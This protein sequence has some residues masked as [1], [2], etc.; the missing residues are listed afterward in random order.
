MYKEKIR[1]LAIRFSKLRSELEKK[2]R[3]SW[4]TF[5]AFGKFKFKPQKDFP[6]TSPN[7]N[8]ELV[9][10]YIE[11]LDNLIFTR[12]EKVREIAV[13]APFSGGKSSFLRTYMKQRPSLLIEIISLAAFKSEKKET[14]ERDSD[15]DQTWTSGN[16]ESDT[17]DVSKE[18]R[19]EKSILQQLLYRTS[20]NR[21]TYS[22][23]RRIFP[24][25]L[26]RITGLLMSLWLITTG[27]FYYSIFTNTINID[28][29]IQSLLEYDSL[30]WD[31]Y[32]SVEFLSIVFCT[33]LPVLLV[34]DSIQFFRSYSLTKLNPL[35]GEFAFSEKSNDSIFNKYLEEIIYYFAEQKTDIVIFEDL[36]RF[37]TLE[38]FV[39]LKELNKLVND[40]A[41]VKQPVRFIYALKDDVFKGKT[42]TKFFDSI[43]PIVPYTNTSNS[44]PELT[45]LIKKYLFDK[46]FGDE[47]LRDISVFLDDMRMIN[48]IVAEYAIYKDV[49]MESSANRDLKKL[50]AF[51][52]YKN[53]YSDDFALLNENSGK[54]A[55]CFNSIAKIRDTVRVSITSEIEDLEKR[56]TQIESEKLEDEEE[57]I[58]L[59]FRKIFIK[60]Y[61]KRHR[62]INT[63]L[64]IDITDLFEHAKF[65]EHYGSLSQHTFQSNDGHNRNQNMTFKTYVAKLFPT[66]DTRL[67]LLRDKTSNQKKNI[68]AQISE[69]RQKNSKISQES[70]AAICK[71]HGKDLIFE[72]FKS[73]NAKDA[74]KYDLL[75]HM[76]ERGYLDQHYHLYIY[77]HRDGV[78]N[79]E[80]LAYLRT[81]KRG[82]DVLADYLPTDIAEFIKYL[83]N[84]DYSRKSFFNIVIINKML[85]NALQENAVR[86]HFSSA[87][88]DELELL[89]L[90]L[91]HREEFLFP[92]RISWMIYE[93]QQ[94][95]LS[96]ITTSDASDSHVSV[97]IN[98][99]INHACDEKQSLRKEKS[100]LNKYISTKQQFLGYASNYQNPSVYLGK[101]KELDVCFEDVHKS[102]HLKEVMLTIFENHMYC[103]NYPNL[104]AFMA[105][106]FDISPD[107]NGCIVLDELY[108]NNDGTVSSL[109][110]EEENFVADCVVNEHFIVKTERVFTT[111]LS[112]EVI[113]SEM[114]K[115]LIKVIDVHVSSLDNIEASNNEKS[116]PREEIIQS[117]ITEEKLTHDHLVQTQLLSEKSEVGESYLAG[118]FERVISANE[119]SKK[120][121]SKLI[122]VLL[123]VLFNND[124]RLYAEK[125]IDILDL[126][127]N[128]FLIS[129]SP[130]ETLE[131]YVEEGRIEMSVTNYQL[132]YPSHAAVA[133]LL[134]SKDY[135]S[136]DF[137]PEGINFTQE[138]F[139]EVMNTNLSSG[140][141]KFLLEN[142]G[143]LL[144]EK[145]GNENIIDWIIE[146]SKDDVQEIVLSKEGVR[147]LIQAI[148]SDQTEKRLTFF[149]QQFSG[150][151]RAE[152]IDLLQFIDIDVYKALAENKRPKVTITPAMKNML[153]VLQK[154]DLISSYTEEFGQYRINP[155]RK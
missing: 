102:E 114:K 105:A 115:F 24:H 108:Q 56:I 145:E 122:Q 133:Y 19:I 137:N 29:V 51:V 111:L 149:S 5:Q 75:K 132:I 39:N 95:F 72:V 88:D 100:E 45:K 27:F 104:R 30:S 97:F 13:T 146:F 120:F 141:K 147:L 94:S 33:A 35:K 58:S 124:A 9:E 77:H 101:L 12:G 31:R 142:H 118:Y 63:I 107:G 38:I 90:F 66:F 57:L 144:S 11:R 61:V 10:H 128:E 150:L 78:L 110:A 41:D 4:K 26:G 129:V 80:D 109:L 43:I 103:L 34:K 28:D 152:A 40:S 48:N 3:S 82:A 17:L 92:Q 98:D 131:K 32:L 50:F 140:F 46:D 138:D 6:D 37:E 153:E 123:K 126:E 62:Q 73:D 76:I 125:V 130:E 14:E 71:S 93:E 23:F 36:D 8:A 1:R 64:N 44:Y 60:H 21:A 148:S 49:L 42:R 89:E 113:D 99:V 70:I 65:M 85:S 54:L 16:H 67:Q 20:S 81:I 116:T 2:V 134:L 25:P 154:N 15:D 59:C 112:S 139:Y 121:D 117:L 87:Y 68:Q 86:I 106:C 55:E 84:H 52:V 69:L 135:E 18:N 151:D 143:H 22:R 83:D 127:F 47:F 155:K 7:E 74:R 91:N 119:L 136:I 79:S 53:N 96:R